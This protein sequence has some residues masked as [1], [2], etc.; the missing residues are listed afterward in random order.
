MGIEELEKQISRRKFLAGLGLTTLS[1]AFAQKA[2]LESRT[3]NS[4]GVGTGP[5]GGILGPDDPAFQNAYVQ[6]KPTAVQTLKSQIS[7]SNLALIIKAQQANVPNTR[8]DWI[9][10]GRHA[11]DASAGLANKVSWMLNDSGIISQAYN[12]L[13]T[14]W[15]YDAGEDPVLVTFAIADDSIDFPGSSR[16]LLGTGNDDAFI[17]DSFNWGSQGFKG[18]QRNVR[19]STEAYDAF[20]APYGFGRSLFIDTA[21]VNGRIDRLAWREDTTPANLRQALAADE[22]DKTTSPVQIT[23]TATGTAGSTN[24]LTDQGHRHGVSLAAVAQIA[25]VGDGLEAA[26]SSTTVPRGDHKHQLSFKS[27]S[28]DPTTTDITAGNAMLWKNTT[29]GELRLWAND[30][31]TLKSVLLS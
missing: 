31:G 25:N 30:G 17:S 5:G 13:K 29:S 27:A 23:A 3:E 10:Q 26:G 11:D 7:N 4:P 1:V 19:L 22:L 28:A 20:N 15:D 12:I 8:D 16:L 21:S 14:A 6:K 2:I 18:E 9:I 24:R